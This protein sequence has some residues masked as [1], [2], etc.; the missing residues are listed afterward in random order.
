MK[1]SPIIV[2]SIAQMAVDI[3]I[4]LVEQDAFAALVVPDPLIAADQPIRGW[5]WRTRMM[6]MDSSLASGFHND[7]RHADIRAMR[8]IGDGELVMIT[9]TNVILG[10]SFTAQ[11]SGL[12]RTLYLL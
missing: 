9:D 8:K 6:P 3:G 2:G 11:L 7:E 12:V 5:V 4:G 10:S 1:A